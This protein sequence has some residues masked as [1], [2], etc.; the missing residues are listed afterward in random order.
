MTGTLS[1]F[2]GLELDLREATEVL[3][4]ISNERLLSC[5]LSCSA[6]GSCRG[7]QGAL[8]TRGLLLFDLSRTCDSRTG[9]EGYLDF[10][11]WD[12]FWRK[13]EV[14]LGRTGLGLAGLALRPRD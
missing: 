13:A 12:V 5:W 11:D 9:T 1:D 4:A 2:G 10:C 3:E 8:L 14:R 6:T 7:L